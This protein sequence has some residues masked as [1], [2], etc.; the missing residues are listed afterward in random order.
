MMN[1]FSLDDDG[2]IISVGEKWLRLQVV[3]DDIVRVTFSNDRQFFS[4]PSL[5]VLRPRGL[6]PSVQSTSDELVLS[7]AKVRAKVNF[8]NGNITFTDA[9]GKVLLAEKARNLAP[10]N[11]QGQDTFHVQQQ[12]QPFADESL[13]GLGENQ[14]GLTDIKGYDLDLWQHN[15]TI[16]IPLLVSSRGYGIFWDNAS[17]TRFGDLRPFSRMTA[18]CLLDADGKPVCSRPRT[19]PMPNFASVC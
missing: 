7:T 8:A 5:A 13:Y 15:G 14:L 11:V 2:V 1:R 3:S 12:W 6:R 10:A 16:V 9:H 18:E 17:F 4:R 19:S